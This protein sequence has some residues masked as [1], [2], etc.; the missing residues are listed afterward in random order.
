MEQRGIILCGYCSLK[1]FESTAVG[2]DYEIPLC[3]DCYE[4]YRNYSDI[5]RSIKEFARKFYP[6]KYE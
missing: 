5:N 2:I 1:Q 4:D 6:P 3:S